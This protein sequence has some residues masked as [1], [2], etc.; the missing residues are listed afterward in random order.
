MPDQKLIGKWVTIPESTLKSKE[1]KALTASTRCVYITMLLK[2]KRKDVIGMADIM[3]DM[4]IR[5]GYVPSKCT[6]DGRVVWALINKSEDPCL[7]CNESRN[8]CGGRPADESYM[9]KARIKIDTENK[10]LFPDMF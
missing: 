3:K 6:L 5:Q 8:I 10:I 9:E 1:W 2:Y 4:V 7:G